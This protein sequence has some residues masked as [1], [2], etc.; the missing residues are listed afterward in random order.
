MTVIITCGESRQSLAACRSLGRAQIPVAVSASRRPSLAMWSR[1]ATSTFLLED[2][3]S[4][5]NLFAEHLAD[6]LYGRYALCALAGSDDSLWAISRFRE[7]FPISARRLLPPHYSVVRS[8]DHQ[9]LHDFAESLKIPCAPLVRI[10]KP[11][12][13]DDLSAALKAFSYPMLFRPIIPWIEREDGARKINQRFVV[14]SKKEVESIF[15]NKYQLLENGVLVSAYEMLRAISYFGVADKGKVLAEG[16]QERLNEE[17]PY[18]EVATLAMTIEPIPAI[19]RYSQLLIEALQW[20][21]PFKVE[22]ARNRKGQYALISL[23][24]RLWGS[25]QLSISAGLNVPLI[26]YRLAEGTVTDE[27]LKNAR[28]QVQMRWLMGDIYSKI[29]NPV[30]FL[31]SLFLS[32]NR[33]SF[34]KNFT[35]LFGLGKSNCFDVLDIEDPMPFVFELQHKTWRVALSDR[36]TVRSDFKHML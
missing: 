24:G 3:G 26:C 31:R 14:H 30:H 35:G 20:Q 22:F 7:F 11:G 17:E 28:P 18:N 6:E 8:L 27:I 13:F 4:Q 2:P 21:G 15:H 36:N 5:P 16:F 1:Y 32:D 25:V 29:K 19:R 12:S 34:Y 9:A 10:E 33:Q 23:I